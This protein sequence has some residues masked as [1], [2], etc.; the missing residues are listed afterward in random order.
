MNKK[1]MLESLVREA[2]EKDLFNGTWLYAE[3]GEVIFKGALGFRDAEDKLP[4][5]EDSIFD[6]ASVSL[7]R[8]FFIRSYRFTRSYCFTRS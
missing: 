3:H 6:L 5:R 4:M 1:A 7:L 2:H 8:S